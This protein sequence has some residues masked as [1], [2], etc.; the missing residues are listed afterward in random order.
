[1]LPS[2]SVTSSAIRETHR[3]EAPMYNYRARKR[4]QSLFRR[5]FGMSTTSFLEPGHRFAGWIGIVGSLLAWFSL[6]CLY[7]ATAGDLDAVFHPATALGLDATALQ[8]FR[9]AMLADMFGFYLPALIVGGYLWSSSRQAAGALKDIAVLSLL[10][11]VVFG[12]AGASMQ[13][14]ALPA[15]SDAHSAGDTAVKI[16]V[17]SAWLAIVSGTEHGLWWA[18]G[19]VM[20]LWAG[21]MGLVLRRQGRAFGVLLMACGG[22]YLLSFVAE[23][24]GTRTIAEL[25]E[26]LGVL[27]FPLW[28]L[29]TGIGLVRGGM[30]ASLTSEQAL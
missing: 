17:E 9:V 4:K 28:L 21:L 1:M 13:L 8:W 26:T 7:A 12:I 10:L 20:G 27:L 11:Y 30:S 16:A 24:L 29:L 25:C 19:P 14:A 22:L 23:F 6:Y 18:E 3:S 2:I 5:G 15:L